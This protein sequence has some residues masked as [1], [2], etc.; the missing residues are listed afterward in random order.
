MTEGNPTNSS[1]LPSSDGRPP[2]DRWKFWL[3]GLLL[4]TGG[5]LVLL[6]VAT[7]WGSW[8]YGVVI[9]IPFAIG[10]AL[11]YGVKAGKVALLLLALVVASGLI[12]GAVTFRIAGILCGIVLAGT[13]I[14]PILLGQFAGYLLRRNLRSS[15]FSQRWYLPVVVLFLLTGGVSYLEHRLVGRG[16]VEYVRTTRVL[17]VDALR[18]W[19]S[20]VFYEEIR[21]AP[22]LLARIGLP[23]PLY[24]SGEIIGVGDTKTCVY[25]TGRLVKRITEY[26]PA[27]FLEFDV[28]EQ[29]GIEDH[30]VRLISGSFRFE[31]IGPDQTRVI[32][33]TVYEPLLT[34]RLAWRPFERQLA[35]SL[36]EHVLTGIELESRHRGQTLIARG[37]P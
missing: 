2:Y 23:H 18:A 36:H 34:A 27:E 30:S 35:R 1:H 37:G 33:T 31:S 11:G 3:P 32:L 12:G 7:G 16:R 8:G 22:P 4:A 14:G 24:T 19:D 6:L 5:G 29:H 21:H 13:F 15:R 20:L 9:G 25:T 10:C 17:P 26:R 28:I